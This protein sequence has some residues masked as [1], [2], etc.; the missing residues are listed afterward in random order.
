[1]EIILKFIET[2]DW[3]TA[4]FQVIPQRKITEA[5]AENVDSA[6][7]EVDYVD[8]EEEEE[9]EGKVRKKKKKEI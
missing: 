5:D 4:F 2:K 6:A 7:V 1:M 3:K 9:V 8:D